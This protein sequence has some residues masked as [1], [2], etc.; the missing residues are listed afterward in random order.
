MDYVVNRFAFSDRLLYN[1]GVWWT[2]VPAE[3]VG[4]ITFLL[5][6][7]TSSPVNADACLSR[8]N[9]TTPTIDSKRVF[10]LCV[11]RHRTRVQRWNLAQ[12]IQ[13]GIHMQHIFPLSVRT[14]NCAYSIG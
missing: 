14:M 2:A 7:C 11:Y 8:L 5:M 13:R 6:I 4:L 3:R 9:P 1:L 12:K 10:W